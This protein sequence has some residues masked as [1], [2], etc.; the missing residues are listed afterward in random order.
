VNA[1]AGT[2]MCAAVFFIG[3]WVATGNGA[4]GR[5]ASGA[6]AVGLLAAGIVA[7]MPGMIFWTPALFGDG[8]FTLGVAG[9]I[10]LGARASERRS[11]NA[12]FAV[13]VA[14]VATAFVRSQGLLVIVPVAVLLVR[15]MDWREAVRALAPVSAALALAIVPWAI[16]NQAAMG[17]AYLI[18]DNG[19]YN[20]RGAHAPYA[21]G[22]TVAVQD[23][24][25]EAPG[26][27]FH[28]RERLFD[29][30]GCDRAWEYART[31]PR[32]EAELALKR[33]GWLWRSDA[34]DAMRWSESLGATPMKHGDRDA[35]VLIG[36]VAWYAVLGLAG[37]SVFVVARNRMVVALWSLI[38]AWVAL[39]VVF[40]GEPRYHM[41][42]AP[43][44]A[45]LGA[46]AIV[47]IASRAAARGFALPRTASRR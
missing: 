40:H 16:R 1:V 34:A 44:L 2:L 19:C 31:H 47:E 33:V 11:L 23:L 12:Y 39:H 7:V 22:T 25:D 42:L 8:V 29:D 36:D 38:A 30:I 37:L 14:L 26:I 46:A 15:S 10:V 24:W 41:A 18:S 13:G 45:A 4:P 32:R 35:L 28:D 5:H 9:T 17:K 27:S 43:A 6:D 21:T 3:R 20:L